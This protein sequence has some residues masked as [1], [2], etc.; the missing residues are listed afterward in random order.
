[1]HVG[2]DLVRRPGHELLPSSNYCSRSGPRPPRRPAA[3]RGGA[4]GLGPHRSHDGEIPSTAATQRPEQV[5]LVVAVD[6]PE[7]AI[8]S[9]DIEADDPVARQSV[10][11]VEDPETTA[12]GQTGQTDRWAGASGQ[13]AT[14]SGQRGVD[15]D[16]LGPC[17]DGGHAG[18]GVVRHRPDRAGVDHQAAGHRRRTEVGVATTA[19][20]DSHTVPGGELH[21]LGNVVRT[22][23]AHH[24][25]RGDRVPARVI[26]PMCR[27]KPG[28][29]GPQQRTVEPGGEG[30]PVS[31]SRWRRGAPGPTGPRGAGARGR[32]RGRARARRR[33]A[34]GAPGQR[35]RRG[36]PAEEQRP[37]WQPRRARGRSAHPDSTIS[38]PGGRPE[39]RST[40]SACCRITTAATWSTTR[41]PLRSRTPDRRKAEPRH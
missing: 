18:A 4:K 29:P 2:P 10:G 39:E 14:V 28:L 20:S 6:R 11:P 17:A 19:R 22:G 23:G 38:S 33:R 12:L 9:H 1:M 24:R 41:R 40:S 32:A 26:E 27:R 16:Q 25:G 13:P 30:L 37:P 36:R 8:G 5:R 15:V 34:A 3:D 35:D 21:R 7:R 31:R